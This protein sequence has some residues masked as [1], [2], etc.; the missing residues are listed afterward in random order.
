MDARSGGRG[1][2]VVVAAVVVWGVAIAGA[3]LLGFPSEFSLIAGA[4]AGLPGVVPSAWTGAVIAGRDRHVLDAPRVRLTRYA[5]V[6]LSIGLGVW[7]GRAAVAACE[8]ARAAHG[9]D[10]SCV[11]HAIGGLWIIAACLPLATAAAYLA[12]RPL[13]AETRRPRADGDDLRA[14]MRGRSR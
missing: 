5:G 3:A 6:L 1:T 7:E 8:A 14:T 11:L 9:G 13:L 4:L 12:A 10:S 2:V